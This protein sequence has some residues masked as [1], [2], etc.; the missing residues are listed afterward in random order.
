[1]EGLTPLVLRPAGGGGQMEA[2]SST[3]SDRQHW[4]IGG[5]KRGMSEPG[6]HR[7]PTVAITISAADEHLQG[8][9]GMTRDMLLAALTALP[10][11]VRWQ[12]SRTTRRPLSNVLRRQSPI[13]TRSS[14]STI[15]D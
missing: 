10:D 3:C 4:T 13:P 5:C 9:A 6:L 2:A 14:S 7:K 12:A 11:T 15:G 8:E 1:M